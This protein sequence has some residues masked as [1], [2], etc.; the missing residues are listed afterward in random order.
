MS[1][2]QASGHPWLLTLLGAS[3]S[4]LGTTINVKEKSLEHGLIGNQHH[5]LGQ[6]YR[7]PCTGIILRNC[8]CW[9]N[10]R[11]ENPRMQ[12]ILRAGWIFQSGCVGI[13]LCCKQA[14]VHS[15]L[16][17]L[18]PG[19]WLPTEPWGPSQLS[20]NEPQPFCS[21][22]SFL[23]PSVLVEQKSGDHNVEEKNLYSPDWHCLRSAL[24]MFW[25]PGPDVCSVLQLLI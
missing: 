20:H 12:K 21:I 23:N 5:I 17:L 8:F 6:G 14:L 1:P 25:P 18:S 15:A 4:K 13:C 3:L 10:C 9:W 16:G 11:H 22:S 7:N 19:T 2:D 24:L